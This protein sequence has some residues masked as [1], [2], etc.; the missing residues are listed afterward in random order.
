MRHLLAFL[1]LAMSQPVTGTASA[2]TVDIELVLAVD[3]SGSVDDREYTLQLEGIAQGFRDA[4]VRRA[5]RSG[6][7]KS[8]AV[9]LLVWAEPQIPKDMT[10]WFVI[11]SDAEAEHFAATVATFPRRQSGST[12]IGEGIAAA[13]RAIDGNDIE[14]ARAVV[15]VSG[16]GRESVAREFTVL[17]GQARAMALSRGIVI[18]G[19]AIQNEVSDL[20]DY[21]RR[22]VQAGPDSFVM[23]ARD[24]EDFAEAMRLK[25]L[26]E[27]EYRPRLA[28]R[29]R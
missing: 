23:T 10:G 19:L 15:D 4:T 12:A 28:F 2:K 22:N 25:L 3:A 7:T 17:V 1:L 8:I 20:A 5:I 26:R 6:P 11:T 29:S 9:N 24:Y 21:Y 14:A 16:D 13:L 18:N 27:I